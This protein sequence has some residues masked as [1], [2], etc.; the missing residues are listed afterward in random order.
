[1]AIEKYWLRVSKIFTKKSI[2]DTIDKIDTWYKKDRQHS[3]Q[4]KKSIA[5][6][7]MADIDTS[8]LTSLN[9]FACV[10]SYID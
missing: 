10:Q 9:V 5:D 4:Y 3:N 8:I 6:T 2:G 1:M 7:V